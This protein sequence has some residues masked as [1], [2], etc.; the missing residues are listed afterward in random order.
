[1]ERIPRLLE[2]S[3]LEI[4]LVMPQNDTVE[5]QVAILQA[6]RAF[7]RMRM[8]PPLEPEYWVPVGVRLGQLRFFY[9][10]SKAEQARRIGCSPSYLTEIGRSSM[11]NR[12]PA[13]IPSEDF[14]ISAAHAYDVP[15]SFLFGPVCGIVLD[16]YGPFSE[17]LKYLREQ[18]GMQIADLA[19]KP[20]IPGSFEE[21][22]SYFN[23]LETKPWPHSRRQFNEIDVYH[24]TDA[25]GVPVWEFFGE[26]V[27]P[28]FV[29]ALRQ[30]YLPPYPIR[31]E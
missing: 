6:Y 16:N 8:F 20:T 28:S 25:L 2:R 5:S 22:Y 10:Q 30:L 14:L 26:H 18:K 7:L 21:K 17:G 23:N 1:M 3:R 29:E 15:L 31:L 19:Q 9:G 13:R 12:T 27:R 4:M 11:G 24:V